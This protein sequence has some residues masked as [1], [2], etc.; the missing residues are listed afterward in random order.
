M[1]K[2]ELTYLLG[3]K[4][5]VL[6]GAM[7][8]MIQQLGLEESD[9]R[10]ARF[11]GHP[12][13]LQGCHDILCLTRPDAVRGIHIAYMEAGAD[14]VTTNTFNANAVSLSDY[15]F[16]DSPETIREINV[17]GAR[18]AAEAVREFD[19]V[20][21]RH[22]IVAGT[23]G[24]T[25]STC[26]VSPDVDDPAARSVDYDILYD[27]YLLQAESLIEGGVDVLMFETVFDT[28][29]LKAG[30]DAVRTAMART[31]TDIA[32]LVS[33]T[34]A[35]RSGRTLSGQ[36]LKAFVTSIEPYNCVATIGLN[37]GFGPDGM[38]QYI[39]E[40][41][42]LTP[43]PVSCHPNA[44]LPN[45]LGLYE[46]TPEF[47]ALHA[48]KMLSQNMLNIVGGC[49]GTT[50]EHIALLAQA[51]SSVTP[52]VLSPHVVQPAPLRVSGLEC[53]EITPDNKF[54]NVGERC[55]VAGS[56]KFL[57]LIKEKKY[58][59]ALGIAA[60]QVEDGAMMIDVNMDD[61]LLGAPK[62]MVHFLRYMASDP[63]VAKVPVMVDSSS[64]EVVESALKNLQGKSIVNSISLKEGEK[65]FIE[66]GKRIKELGAA[67][68]VMAFD[69]KGQADTYSRKI[70]VCER[71]YHLLL[72]DCGF[73]PE[74]IIFDVNVMAVAT[75][76]EE[77]ALYGIDFVRAVEWI[78]K[79]LPGARTSGGISNLSFAFRGKNELRE[80][81]HA[82][83]LY[84][85]IKAGLD[86]GIVNPATSVTY[87]D[88][89][90][91]LRTLIEDVVLAR[92]PD[93][94][95]E[96]A[97]Y[98]AGETIVAVTSAHSGDRDTS[99]PVEERLSNAIL[100]GKTDYMESDLKEAMDSGLNPEA[101][102]S[103]PLM[104]GMNHAGILFGDGKMFLPQVVKTA[105][106]MK[107]AVD[108]LRP[109]MMESRGDS[110]A[111]KGK[112]IFATVKGDVHDIGKNIAAIVMECNDY[113]VIDLGVMVGSST[114]VD[115]VKKENPDFICLSG[116]ITPS[117]A[118]MTEVAR[119]L[120]ANGIDTP[121]MVGGA[122]TSRLHTALKIAPVYGG[123]VIH[124][125]DAS[126]NPVVAAKL[127]DSDNRDAFVAELDMDYKR[128][129]ME[130]ENRNSLQEYPNDLNSVRNDNAHTVVTPSSGIKEPIIIEL[131]LKDV[132]RFIN[133]K[134]FF[135]AWGM[136]GSFMKG[137]PY[138]APLTEAGIWAERHQ[139]EEREKALESVSLYE[140]ALNAI[141]S[142]G[143]EGFDGMAIVRFCKA[144]GNRSD[145][146][147][148]AGEREIRIPMLRQ[149]YE[150]SERLSMSDFVN[151]DDYIGF[152]AVTSGEKIQNKAAE[153]KAK[154]DDYNG[155]LLQSLAD[156][157]AEAASEWLHAEV[158]KRLWGYAPEESLTVEEM[159]RG[160]YSG[161]RPAVGYPSIPD[162]SLIHIF[163]NLIDY[164]KI[165]ITVTENGAMIPASSV[166]GLYIANPEARYFMIGEIS[167]KALAD[168]ADRRGL[169]I[170]EMRRILRL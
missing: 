132:I 123:P 143:E 52:R 114:I 92:N 160:E 17:S 77:H 67:V 35:D 37:C 59:E 3:E 146:N 55:N 163:T 10:S 70:E 107:F 93:R 18:I 142:L 53:L 6:D 30:L 109:F 101:L 165:G 134:M 144:S 148:K 131:E 108:F 45:E 80:A 34:L 21:G 98:A 137:F 116:L 40:L 138:G 46:E 99:V 33:A 147:V 126:R 159:L 5:L 140:D 47:F 118:E 69:E 97:G 100:K 128:L 102:I 96:L 62:E 135:H 122:T 84:H 88:I 75:G 71:A 129:R 124:V 164:E 85:A 130:Y 86:M 105:R 2:K 23:M 36:T 31:G 15:G 155:L 43:L 22:V 20:S 166:S 27:A 8:T 161:I 112:A 29:N 26:S 167:E 11:A 48:G 1:N 94:Q 57:R 170:E 87:E 136:T 49:C 42:G 28:L 14:I 117:L 157:L 133:W 91:D 66:K 51:A 81:M 73:S 24:P 56:R 64:W 78:K 153:Y 125:A 74:D 162:Q 19:K 120:A 119:D 7:G 154:G 169:S 152:F 110:L 111:K 60:R 127:L 68:I 76:M 82:V 158:R 79:N 54:V 25:G 90:P 151:I 139:G 168:Y 16:G 63:D 106:A 38:M 50:P 121:I 4:V 141:V 150:G 65:V 145:I 156:R 58:D 12:V 83:F 95:A 104:K 115:A 9:Y 89:A 32:V 41:D 44:G 61:P 113:E 103:G 13:N 149:E 72:E 39:K